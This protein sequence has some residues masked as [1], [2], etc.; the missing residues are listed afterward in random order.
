MIKSANKLNV[1]LKEEG[2][3]EEELMRQGVFDSLVPGIC[4]NDTC[5]ATYDYE[6]D[7]RR[8]WCYEC[9]T[10]SVTSGLVLLGVM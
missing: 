5:N 8:G 1:L 7:C 2:L 4:M 6:P 9:E 10:N 3:T